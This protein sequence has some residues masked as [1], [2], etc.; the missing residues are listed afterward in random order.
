MGKIILVTG[1]AR[2]GKSSFAEKYVQKHGKKTAYIATAQILDEEMKQR[3]L[4]H[5]KHRETAD[6]HTLEAPFDAELAIDDCSAYD[7]VLFDCLT[8]YMS[9]LICMSQMEK[10]K[11]AQRQKMIFGAIEK[12]ICAAKKHAGF[13]VFVTNEVGSGIVP[14]NALARQYRDIAGF[15]NQYAAEK[16]DE[17]YFV[18]S[19]IPVKIK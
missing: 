7:A 8:V 14:E 19:G 6:W 15:C 16:A 11:A 12:L 13:I 4:L 10:K 5:R 2:S 17:V 3:V 18:V 9:N 1:G